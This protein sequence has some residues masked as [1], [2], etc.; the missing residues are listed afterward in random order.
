MRREKEAE[1]SF[2]DAHHTNGLFQCVTKRNLHV[3]PTKYY[4]EKKKRKIQ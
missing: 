1:G 4:I 2:A 3:W